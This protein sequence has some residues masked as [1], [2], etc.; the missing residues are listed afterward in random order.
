MQS[1]VQ[2]LEKS[3]NPGVGYWS[4]SNP[5]RGVTSPSTEPTTPALERKS[6]ESARTGQTSMTGSGF[7]TP[8]PNHVVDAKDKGEEEVNLEVGLGPK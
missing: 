7:N 1:S 3:R 4:S 6:M 2:L 8:A 5:S